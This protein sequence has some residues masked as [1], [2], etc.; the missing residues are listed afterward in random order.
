MT[1]LHEH[2]RPS[3][4]ARGSLLPGGGGSSAAA[5]AAGTRSSLLCSSE[6]RS[7]LAVA[8][9]GT[10]APPPRGWP[11]ATKPKLIGSHGFGGGEAIA[12]APGA[13]SSAWPASLLPSP[14]P[15]GSTQPPHR[16]L[17]G[18]PPL[19]LCSTRP[20]PR[21]RHVLFAFE[22]RGSVSLPLLSPWKAICLPFCMNCWRRNHKGTIA[23][24]RQNLL[25]SVSQ[26]I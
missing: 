7:L 3:S 19:L 4:L 5:R 21:R 17:A 8:Q 20:A 6:T 14:A 25:D 12:V 24:G 18:A 11:P 13:P 16:P 2:M 26:R 23:S 9:G 15:L 22:E 10:R 1:D